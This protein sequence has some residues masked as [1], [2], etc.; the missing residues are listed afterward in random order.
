[1]V[2]VTHDARAAAAADRI[3]HYRDGRFVKG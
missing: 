2:M 1:V 3:L